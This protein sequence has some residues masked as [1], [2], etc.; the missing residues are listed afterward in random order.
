MTQQDGFNGGSPRMTPEQ[1][2]QAEQAGRALIGRWLTTLVRGIMLR[3][4][5]D[6]SGH[7]HGTTL[8]LRAKFAKNFDLPTPEQIASM[9]EDDF[10]YKE[11]YLKNV[12]DMAFTPAATIH[13]ADF[14]GEWPPLN[15]IKQHTERKPPGIIKPSAA[16]VNRI[17]RGKPN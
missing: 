16:E 9:S 1:E 14:K 12:P 10:E 15:L 2:K 4:P 17:V 8:Y 6:I 11:L 3:H 13:E 5:L 7:G